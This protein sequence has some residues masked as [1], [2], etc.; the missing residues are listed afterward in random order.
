VSA[1]EDAAA[2]VAAAVQPVEAVA[3]TEALVE[4][5]KERYEY[6]A[7]VQRLMDIIINSL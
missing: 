2:P 5:P 1:T 7:E 4:A 3:A 6:Q